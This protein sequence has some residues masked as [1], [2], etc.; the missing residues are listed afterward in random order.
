MIVTYLLPF[1]RTLSPLYPSCVPRRPAFSQQTCDE[2]QSHDFDFFGNLMVENI[3][4]SKI[5]EI[6]VTGHELKSGIGF[7]IG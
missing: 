2:S 7:I 6:Q 4:T 3:D 5:D 1:F